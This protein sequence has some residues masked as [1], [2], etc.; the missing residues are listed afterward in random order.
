MASVK[1]RQ[2]TGV[3]VPVP[4][5]HRLIRERTSVHQLEIHRYPSRAAG[6]DRSPLPSLQSGFPQSRTARQCPAPSGT[7]TISVPSPAAAGPN[8]QTEEWL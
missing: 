3:R 7:E 1:A 2:G 8:S 5:C 6:H 4:S